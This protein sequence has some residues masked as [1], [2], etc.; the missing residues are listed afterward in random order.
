MTEPRTMTQ[1]IEAMRKASRPDQES[2]LTLLPGDHKAISSLG[3][4]VDWVR[5]NGACEASFRSY[6]RERMARK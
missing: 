2:T 5:Q 3:F 1:L 4:L 6:V